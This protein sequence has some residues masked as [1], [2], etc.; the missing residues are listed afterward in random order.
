MRCA[1]EDDTLEVGVRLEED[2]AVDE[3]V[4]VDDG[5][6]DRTREIAEAA[7]PKVRL[8]SSPQPRSG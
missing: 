8:A 3:I 6:T 1:D 2:R 7:G 4:L 5:S